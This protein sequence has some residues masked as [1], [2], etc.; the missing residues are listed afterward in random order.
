[1]IY[2]IGWIL[3]LFMLL[4]AAIGWVFEQQLEQQL[5]DQHVR[6]KTQLLSVIAGELEHL[7]PFDSLDLD[8]VADRLGTHSNSRVSLIR[9]DGE[10][11]GDS[12]LPANQL[13][14][15]DNHGQRPEVMQALQG[16]TGYSERLSTSLGIPMLYLARLSADGE[17][18]VRIA[19]SGAQLREAIHD[20]RLLIS[21]LC[22]L[23]LTAVGGLWFYSLQFVS[24]SITQEKRRLERE[25]LEHHEELQTLQAV[26]EML[27]ACVS[28]KEIG[29]VIEGYFRQLLGSHSGMLAVVRSSRNRLEVATSWGSKINAQPF[30]PSDC[31]A[32]RLGHSHYDTGSDRIQHC[33]HRASPDQGQA[34][35]IPLVARGEILGSLNLELPACWQPDEEQLAFCKSVTKQ[36]SLALANIQLN[37][38]LRQQAIRDAL[39][40]LYNRRFM[41]ESLEAELN[42]A[43]RHKHALSLLMLDLDHFKRIN[44]RFGHETGDKTLRAFALTIQR[45]C[46]REDIPCRYGGE[47]FCVL[48]P[49]TD[50][51]CAAS[52]AEKLR[53]A[54]AQT[55]VR[56]PGGELIP[57]TVSIG[58]ASWSDRL[59]ETE[60]LINA[61]DEALYQAKEQGRNRIVI[62]EEPDTTA[63]LCLEQR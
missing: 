1:M 24:R 47:E 61:A 9:P 56:S 17:L 18:V 16:D 13:G 52:V 26:G 8:A 7:P 2:R 55:E 23:L 49:E 4:L 28:I 48:L 62:A 6:E 54:T 53:K 59:L 43:Q 37:E 29:D 27:G 40:N 41:T 42:R 3:S 11:I 39:T 31:W 33:P 35:C 46:R 51:A 50:R 15:L 38:S 21:L 36:A 60:A 45:N 58:V 20:L 30:A 14:A 12:Q 57:L 44:D 34:L 22:I 25:I 19:L 63:G 32:L 10:V 5:R